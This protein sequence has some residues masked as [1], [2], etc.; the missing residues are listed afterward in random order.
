MKKKDKLWPALSVGLLKMFRIM[1]LT[2]FILLVALTQSFAVSSYSQSTKLTMNYKNAR[3]E[4]IIDAIEENTEFYFL[5]NKDMV[6]V[7]RKVD[8]NVEQKSV[9]EVLD[10][11]FNNTDISYSIRDRLIL[12]IKKEIAKSVPEFTEQQPNRITGN[13]TDNSGLPLP[14]V[15]VIIKGT[16]S[17]TVTNASGEYTITGV[18]DDAILQF[19]FVGMRTQEVAVENQASINVVLQEETI[20]IEEIIAVGYGTQKRESLTGSLQTVESKSLQSVTTPTVENMLSGKIPGVFVASGSGQPGSEGSIIIRGKSTINGNTDPLWVIDG[21][22]V[23]SGAGALNPS[24][25][26]TVTILKDAASTSIYGSQGANGV[27]VVTTKSAKAEKTSINV[28]AKIGL[29]SLYNGNLEVMNG[30]EL[31]DYYKSFSN[32]DE[33][34]FPRWNDD[35]RNSNFDWWDF[36][37]QTGVAQDYNI[38]VNG[39]NDMLK[40]Y[41]SVGVYDEKGAVKGYD[42]TRY[43]FRYKTDYTPFKWLTIKPTIAGSRKDIKDKQ[44]S[45]SAMYSNLPWDS[46]YDGSGNIIG[47]YSSLWVNSNSTNYLY[48]LQWNYSESRT[49]EFM[50]NLDFDIN[51]TDWLTFSSVNNYKWVGYSSMYYQD[52]RSSGGE[53]VDGRINEYQSNMNRRYTNQILRFNKTLGDHN[54]NALIAYEF[55]DYEFKSISGTG[56]GIVAGFNVLDVTSKPEAVG[57]S[58]SEW[59]VQSFLFNANYS[60]KSRYYGQLSL[61][62]DGASNFGEDEKYGNFFSVGGGWILSREN[63]FDVKW[64][65]VLKLRVSY[66][67]VG[68]RPSSLYPQ[69]DLY[70]VTESYNEVPG[71]LISQV[72]N[73]E[74]TW[75]RTYTTGIGLDATLF[76]RLRL[77]LDYYEKKTDNLLYRVPVSGVTGV[78][79]IWR[80]V[81]EVNNKGFETSIG[82]DIMKTTELLWSVDVNLGL[83]R[84]KVV[85]LYDNNSQIILGSSIA[86]SANRILRPGIDSDTWYLREW[87][88]V[89]P[90]TGGPLWYKT[91]ENGG[92]V[93]TNN[94]AEADQVELDAYTPDF[95]GGFS[96]SLNYKNF[97]LNANFSYSVGGKIYNYTRSEYDSDGAYTD[98]NQMKLMDGW[99]RWE[100]PGD[101]ATHPLPGYNNSSNSNKVSSRYLEDGDYLKLKNLTLGYNFTLPAYKISNVRVYVSG[102]NLFTITDYSGVDPEIPPRDGS[103][104]GVTTTVYPSTRKFIFGVNVTF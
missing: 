82:F 74:L 98:R 43:N 36:A 50:G 35:L 81:G 30:A 47:H 3:V 20:G 1:R 11:V 61:R 72:G 65:N 75:E 22:I 9:N 94:Y 59:A 5:Y 10:Q 2:I 29:T 18:P 102:E 51:L 39:G 13:V 79:S 45:V 7:D 48:D 80:N 37:S 32:V 42:Y 58:L 95:F 85:K 17:G 67:S 84:N 46:A 62:R 21:V 44:H 63:W 104:T 54:I 60:Y 91:D 69:Y 14:G 57:G 92:R 100:Q 56:T 90:E 96:T 40:S 25:I 34:S 15:S 64:A 38:S 89:D 49:W 83:N 70:S 77:T 99:S 76:S 86:G 12:L 23:G 16:S 33:I 71:A 101:I 97:D 41:L 4:E 24:D 8:I 93:T 68:N 27:I 53:G 66:G 73:N 28:S 52:P 26:E 88:G 19:S 103:I 78:T 87:A 55:N 6:D 31:Y